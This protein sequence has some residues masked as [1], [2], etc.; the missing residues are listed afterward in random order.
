MR[1]GGFWRN[2]RGGVAI[3]AAISS[4]VLIAFAALAVD[5]G[6]I[7]LQTRQ[8]QGI[9]DLAAL[10]AAD[11][12][13]NAQAAAAATASGNGW[14]GP[15]QTAVVLGTYVPNSAIPAAQRFTA[16]GT[17]P[18]AVQVTLTAQ[19]QL[20][21]GQAILGKASVPI[22]RTAT[23][24]T[25]QAASFSL[26]SGLASLQGGVANALLSGLT[27]SSVAL[28]VSDYNSLASAN[29]DLLQFSQA[30]QTKL[31]L[32]GGSFT[33]VLSSNVSTGQA[34]SVLSTLLNTG[35]N[36]PAAQAINTIATAAG[37]ATPAN[38]Q[39]L[40]DLGPYAA[41]DHADPATGAGVSVNA[42]QLAS[43][44]LQLSQGGHQ[45]QLS[46]GGTIP[47]LASTTVWLAIGQRPSNSPW[48]TVNDDGTVTVYTAQT[49]L[50]IDAQVAPGA[51]ILNS[52][53]VA[54]VNIPLYV[55]TASAA[56]K[57]SSLS[58]PTST[59]APAVTLSVEPSVGQ[60]NL[61]Q[62]NTAS[63]N[64]FSQPLTP[65]PATLINLLL[66]Q[67]TGQ[68]Q[69]N[70]G[71]GSWQSVSFSQADIA[72]GTTKT[73]S[74][75]NIAQATVASLLPNTTLQIQLLGLNI[76]LGQLGVTS[77]VQQLLTAVAPSLDAVINA[78]EG[79]LGVQLGQAMVT[80]NGLRCNDAALVA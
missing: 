37:T 13:T 79:V 18:N 62:I 25:A 72:A 11:N 9:A 43:A 74:T 16:G 70:L 23:A 48:L 75:N 36:D 3:I 54:L 6:S 58:C 35:G 46:L 69:V 45:I 12:L 8:L 34:L 63:L 10:G 73:V 32:Q 1:R 64:N 77:A 52:A 4:A 29:I 50:Y 68:A 26:G 7:F 15:M 76:V 51:G 5:M 39:Q 71:G 21:F 53:G 19:A 24:A 14:N 78:V 27:G 59:T 30:L 60:I 31:N 49:R 33:Q 56:A 22:K 80:V 41:Q 20:F 38:L 42:L 17:T 65:T 67:V 61:G 40:V 44:I 55:Q 2:R 28:S 66:L 57:L 47:G